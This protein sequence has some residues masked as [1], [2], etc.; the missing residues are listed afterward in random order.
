M[1]VLSVHSP[2]F[3][4]CMRPTFAV[5]GEET[6]AIVVISCLHDTLTIAG[7]R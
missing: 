3:I 7:T 4:Y 6:I 2:L 1:N 5:F